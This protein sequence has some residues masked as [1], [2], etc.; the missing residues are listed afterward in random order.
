MNYYM[1]VSVCLAIHVVININNFRKKPTVNLPALKAYR[2]FAVSVALY[3]VTDL[4]W[5]IFE[6]NKLPIALYID[7]S[8]YFIMMGFSILAWAQYIVK[9]LDKNGLTGKII[10][11][12]G[13][14]FFFAEIVLLIINIFTPVLFRVNMETCAYETYKARN[15]M[16]YVQTLMYFALIIYSAIH[17]F[18]LKDSARR[19]RYMTI[20]LYSII[21]L[22]AVIVQIYNSY[23]P[24]YSIGSIVGACLL[25][26][27]VI[28]DIKEEYKSELEESRVQV[29]QGK[30]QLSETMVIAYSD[31]LTNV[32]NKHA[33]VEEEERID[34]LIAKNQ[35]EN[36]AVVVF[37]LNG[38]KIINDTKGH[39][40]GDVYIVES[41]QVIEKYFGK[42]NLYRFGG[43]EF[44]VILFGEQYNSRMKLIAAF[45]D[46]IDKCLGTDKP[47]ISSGISRYKP[48]EDNTYHAV[49]NRADKQMYS[50]KESLKEHH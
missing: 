48:G 45:E 46:Y 47:I 18:R 35:M 12:I 10:L 20:T 9:Y 19:R 16:L 2:V 26:A 27:F 24:I 37:D 15:I 44:V 29:E 23:S 3:F 28:N 13:N 30:I 6:E 8:F 31:P 1:F 36:F 17:A 50:R 49:F 4:L 38:L 14:A 5:G 43:D 39:D 42:T 34:K 33:Y 41:C 25:T 7:T 32:K 11:Y 22:S 21:M 40:A